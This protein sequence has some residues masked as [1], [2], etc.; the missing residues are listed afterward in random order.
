MDAQFTDALSDRLDI[1]RVAVRQTVNPRG[2]FCSGA[3]IGQT[4]KPVREDFG[5]AN[6]RHVD[7]VAYTLQDGK[8][9]AN[10]HL[11]HRSPHP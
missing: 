5:L 3:S 8:A 7:Y 4:T 1:A 2:D 9:P 6:V 11:V 10:V